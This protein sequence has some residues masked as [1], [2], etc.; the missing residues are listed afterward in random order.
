MDKTTRNSLVWGGVLIVEAMILRLAKKSEIWFYIL[1]P[2][3]IGF[4]LTE[5]ILPMPREKKRNLK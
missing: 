1:L 2:I 4:L 3:I 5:L